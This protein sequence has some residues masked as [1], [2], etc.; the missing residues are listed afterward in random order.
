MK[1]RLP[2]L[3]ILALGAGGYYWYWKTQQEA[4]LDGRILVSGNLELTQVDLAFKTA[5][6]LVE[7]MVREGDPVKKGDIIARLDAAQ[8]EQ[9]RTRDLASVAGA[10]SQYE[11]LQT[12]IEFQR[13]TI[14]S[15]IALR[16]A[17]LTQVQAR[18]DDL[19]AGSR[20]QEIQQALAAV[21]DAKAWNDVAKLE[22]ARAQALYAKEDI[23]TSQ[24]DQARTKVDSTAAQLRQ[25]EQR[26]ALVQEGP[27]KDEIAAARAGVARAQAA[28]ATAEAN[29]IEVRRKEQELTSRRAE[30]DRNRAQVGMTQTQIN[31]A[32]LVA[33]IDGV[34]M[35]KAAEAGEVIAAG[36]TVVSLGDLD[37]PWLRAYI[38]ETDMGRIQ[39][40]GKAR[41]STDSFPARK[42]EG[43]ISFISAEAEFTPKQIQTKEERVKLVYR[44]KID[45]DNSARELKNNMP[46]DAELIL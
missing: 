26:L 30:V 31:D 21:T 11:Q 45:V 29:R 15:D 46:V 17:E 41:L 37:H 5:G 34:V 36:T 3:I 42:Y 33:P 8:L 43:R 23:S 24:Y 22:W 4:A 14:D 13:A 38:N 10:Q 28:I 1:K 40:N 32:I 25:A 7:L 6:R 19:M 16:R 27:R 2:I 12:A 44:I 18:L 39:L 9:Q 20:Q 35:V